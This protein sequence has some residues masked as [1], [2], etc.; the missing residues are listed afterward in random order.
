MESPV[1]NHLPQGGVPSYRP[2]W[3]PVVTRVSLPSPNVAFVQ[4]LHHGNPEYWL[5]KAIWQWLFSGMDTTMIQKPD[6]LERRFEGLRKWNWKLY[7]DSKFNTFSKSILDEN[8]ELED[9]SSNRLV[10]LGLIPF[11]QLQFR[12]ESLNP[13]NRNDPDLV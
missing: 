13:F 10:S 3:F 5:Q 11:F 8:G 7:L 6:Y 12:W 1:D 2:S 9:T 4:S